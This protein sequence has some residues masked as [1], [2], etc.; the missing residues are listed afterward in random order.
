MQGKEVSKPA[1]EASRNG[2]SRYKSKAQSWK[3]L[4]TKNSNIQGKVGQKKWNPE[5]WK[6]RHPRKA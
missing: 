1:V 6:K 4:T 3:G 2:L 5:H